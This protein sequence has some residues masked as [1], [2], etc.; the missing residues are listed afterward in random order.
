MGESL[1]RQWPSGHTRS[2]LC[3][4]RPR[5]VDRGALLSRSPDNFNNLTHGPYL[6]FS[7]FVILIAVVMKGSVLCDI[8]Q[9][10]VKAIPVTSRGGP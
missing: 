8:R 4:S 1:R 10:K 3:V 9:C 6:I 7:G 2:S 5:T